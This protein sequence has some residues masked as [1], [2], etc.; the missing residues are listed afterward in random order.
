MSW[1]IA[2]EDEILGQFASACGIMDLRKAAEDHHALL[3]LLDEGHTSDVPAV[4]SDLKEITK[5]DAGS[6]SKAL[7]AL[8]EGETH[9]S[10]TD[11][12]ER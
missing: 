6:I 5:G 4:L 2:N 3:S 11:G 9:V 8:L 12:S 10:I 1:Y 7:S